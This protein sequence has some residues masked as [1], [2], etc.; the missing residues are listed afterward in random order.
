MQLGDKEYILWKVSR[1]LSCKCS[2]PGVYSLAN[3][4]KP[5]KALNQSSSNW[6]YTA[7]EI[8]Q[9]S[10]GFPTFSQW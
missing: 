1:L 6:E 10:T 4:T 3:V 2:L 8:E 7:I 9:N 5:K